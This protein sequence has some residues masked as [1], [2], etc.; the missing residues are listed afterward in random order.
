MNKGS[1]LI[2][3]IKSGY[4]NRINLNVSGL[5]DKSARYNGNNISPNDDSY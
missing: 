4:Y 3:S 2:A 1:G 5:G